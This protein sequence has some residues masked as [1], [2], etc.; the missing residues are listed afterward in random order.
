MVGATKISEIRSAAEAAVR[1]GIFTANEIPEGKRPPVWQRYR[2]V[3]PENNALWD[4]M[5]INEQV[6][7]SANI[8]GKHLEVVNE[9]QVAE[10]TRGSLATLKAHFTD[11]EHRSEAKEWTAN[12]VDALIQT[13]PS[14][15]VAQALRTQLWTFGHIN[16]T[17][18][19]NYEEGALGRDPY[20]RGAKFEPVDEVGEA[21]LRWLREKL[22]TRRHTSRGQRG[23]K[24]TPG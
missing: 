17:P 19:A 16:W 22:P 18:P 7:T 9:E 15:A 14:T 4:E 20:G 1:A 12:E 2:P 24:R 21:A 3:D 10:P 13:N 6:I 23:T 5:F 8:L 11:S